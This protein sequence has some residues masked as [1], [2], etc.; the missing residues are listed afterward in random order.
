MVQNV[1]TKQ[2][3]LKYNVKASSNSP[4]DVAGQKKEREASIVT[5]GSSGCVFVRRAALGSAL[6]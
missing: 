5:T 2:K 4:G 6:A 1:C 3:L